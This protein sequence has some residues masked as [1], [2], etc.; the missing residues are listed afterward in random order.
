MLIAENTMKL[1][2]RL[3]HQTL[4]VESHSALIGMHWKI[5]TLIAAKVL[6]RVKTPTHQSTVLNERAAN[7][8]P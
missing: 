6:H 4:M 8:R 2:R 1:S 3:T 5:K 7:I